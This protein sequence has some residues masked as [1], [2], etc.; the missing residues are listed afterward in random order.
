[1]GK[2]I[3]KVET[4]GKSQKKFNISRKYKRRRHSWSL[5]AGKDPMIERT[6]DMIYTHGATLCISCE[7]ASGQG[8]QVK[9]QRT[10]EY[11]AITGK[12]RMCPPGWCNKYKKRER[13][14]RPKKIVINA[15]KEKSLM[16]D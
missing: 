3:C 7:F 16:E 6:D 9:S 8:G 13:K 2:I 14:R 10:C 15:I 1:M 5:A 11:L 4:P 12:R